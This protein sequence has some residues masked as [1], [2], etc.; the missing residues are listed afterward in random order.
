MAGETAVVQMVNL[1]FAQAVRDG[2]S[3]IHIEAY[4]K[5]VKVFN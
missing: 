2:A 3:D 1:I 5:D 4:E